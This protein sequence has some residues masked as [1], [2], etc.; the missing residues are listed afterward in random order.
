MN[1]SHQDLDK[2]QNSAWILHQI[3]RS[4]LEYSL[5]LFEPRVAKH[6]EPFKTNRHGWIMPKESR[7][8]RH[9][10]KSILSKKSFNKSYNKIYEK[11]LRQCQIK[12]IVEKS[13]NRITE[14]Q[15][16]Y[17]I[18]QLSHQKID[19]YQS[20]WRELFQGTRFLPY[21]ELRL[22]TKKRL[23]INDCSW[24][25]ESRP[26]NPWTAPNWSKIGARWWKPL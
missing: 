19:T 2:S 23:K 25:P 8:E 4:E 15:F 20:I 9:F 24:V 11:F 17:K 3:V 10:F 7:Q 13:C 6:P 22:Q 1:Q 21:L 16:F 26:T 5:R 14:R 18:N 12:S